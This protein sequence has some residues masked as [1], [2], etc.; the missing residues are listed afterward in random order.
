MIPKATKKAKARA[1]IRQTAQQAATP[2]SAAAAAAT[3]AVADAAPPEG[4][5]DLEAQANS[6][7]DNT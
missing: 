1:C 2:C 7:D 3:A 4:G 6:G 5:A